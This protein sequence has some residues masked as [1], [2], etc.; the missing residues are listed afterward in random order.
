MDRWLSPH[1][2]RV[3][4]RRGAEH[5]L[6]SLLSAEELYFQLEGWLG[7]AVL[8]DRR[9][10]EL[11]EQQVEAHPDAVAAVCGDRSGPRAAQ[12]PGQPV[13]A[14]A[15]GPRVDREAVVRWSR[16]AIWTGWRLFLRVF[17]AGGVYLPIEPHFPP[18]G[19]QGRSHGPA[20]LVLT[21]LGSTTTLD[22]GLT[23]LPEVETLFIDAAYQEDHA[24]DNLAMPVGPE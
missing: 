16:S 20:G 14:G 7:A 5:R 15:A 9:V 10:H 12:W 1:S 8:P 18:I 23:S 4:G 17:K 2:T 3:D 24:D 21:E 6:Q 19:L 22:H 11:F 13:G